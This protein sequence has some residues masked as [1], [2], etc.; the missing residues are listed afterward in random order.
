MNTRRDR[1]TKAEKY[2]CDWLIDLKDPP[3]AFWY[4]VAEPSEPIFWVSGKAGSGKSTLMRYIHEHSEVDQSLGQ[5]A[6]AQPITKAAYFFS[7]EGGKMASSREGMMRSV[8][9]Q[10]LTSRKDLIPFAYPDLFS[11]DATLDPE[12][13]TTWTSLNEAFKALLQKA[14]GLHVFLLID[15]LDEFRMHE[16]SDDY[17]QDQL[18]LLYDGENDDEGWG[19]NAWI[20]D[21]HNQLANFITD[22]K[23]YNNIKICVAC[24]ELSAF[25]VSFYELPRVRVQDH[26]RPAI[27]QYCERR[28]EQDAISL[29]AT[30]RERL[31]TS[32]T[33]NADGVFL[34]VQLVVDSVIRG[35]Q[36]GDTPEELRKKLAALPPRIGGPKGL[37]MHM[38]RSIDRKHL[39]EAFQ[40]FDLVSTQQYSPVDVE[41]LPLFFAQESLGQTLQK[42]IQAVTAER[43]DDMSKDTKR[44]K[45]ERLNR[46]LMTRTRGLLQSSGQ[47]GYLV[48]FIHLTASQ[49]LKRQMIRDLVGISSTHRLDR[50]SSDVAWFLGL[51]RRIKSDLDYPSTAG[52]KNPPLC[53]LASVIDADAETHVSHSVLKLF[54]VTFDEW[55]SRTEA[56]DNRIMGSG[57]S[58]HQN[59]SIWRL[60]DPLQTATE[61]LDL[62]VL[63][64][65]FGCAAVL[66]NE[67]PQITQRT[68]QRL[69][70]LISHRFHGQ[71]LSTTKDNPIYSKR[72]YLQEL[73][74]L[75]QA[76]ISRGANPNGPV[77]EN[78]GVTPWTLCLE[79]VC[80]SRHI[81]FMWKNMLVTLDLYLRHGADQ[82]ATVE[83]NGELITARE[84]LL[85]AAERS[86]MF[87]TAL[88]Q[89]PKMCYYL[90]V[91]L[92]IP[93][94]PNKSEVENA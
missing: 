53:K 60:I 40:L 88:V 35:F 19:I 23:V 81:V 76:L 75:L 56:P 5:W 86:G 61:F 62:A 67:R 83:V 21:G 51:I 7:E 32:T 30:E 79:R 94:V 14:P 10:I 58:G 25:E 78:A 33:I 84:G 38:L 43:R 93:W 77:D 70:C 89:F 63:H 72:P 26:T 2:T 50:I 13:L 87:A 45:L 69:L 59:S 22:C 20:T 29:P 73:V 36:D 44:L 54:Q 27:K 80:N 46:R 85:R 47:R 68:L 34:W 4:W 18:D 52:S 91:F 57:D 3:P 24:R 8:L 9:H 16:K 1:I 55:P 12:Y 39:V 82:E 92:Q 37:Y 48:H 66:L 65:W 41:I 17:N 6:G 11:G 49:F 64:G 31:V 42:K 90:Q 28:L 74:K 71:F 15:G